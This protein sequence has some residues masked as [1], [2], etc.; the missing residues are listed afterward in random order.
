M[1]VGRNLPCPCGSGK[2]Y[3]TCCDGRQSIP[4][5]ASTDALFMQAQRAHAEGRL[6][7]AQAIYA[8]ILEKDPNNPEAIHFQGLLSHQTGQTQLALNLIERSLALRP[9]N[10]HF[11]TN[12]ALIYQAAGDW[13]KAVISRRKLTQLT[14]DNAKAWHNLGEALVQLGH[15]DEVIEAYRHAANLA[16]SDSALWTDLS[17]RLIHRAHPADLE[18]ALAHSRKVI[19]L[20]PDNAEGHNNLAVALGLL[21]RREEAIKAAQTAIRLTPQSSQP[22][23]NLARIHVLSG[24]VNSALDAYEKGAALAPDVDLFYK[25][26]ANL[27][28]QAGKFNDAI[29]FL[30]LLYERDPKNLAML[31]SFIRYQKFVSV[32]DPL[33]LTARSAVDAAEDKEEGVSMLC[34]VLGS[35]LDKMEQYAAAFGYYNRGNRI[36]A[37]TLHY[38]REAHQRYV[39]SII[40][41]YDTDAIAKLSALGNPSDKPI[42]IVGMPRS[43]TT[44][45]EQIIAV[46]PQVAGGGERDFWGANEPKNDALNQT[47]VNNIA[48]ACLKDL[49]SIPGAD[50][51]RKTTDKMPGNFLR[52]GLIH[53]AFPNARIIHVRRHPVDNCLSIFFQSFNELHQYAFNLEDLVHYR[54][55]YERLMRHWRKVMPAD[56]YFEF[57]Y[58]DLV[59][60][61][62]GMSRKLINFCGLEWDDSSLNYHQNDQ[63]IKTASMWQ[64]RQKI[65]TTSVERWKNYAR[66]IQPLMTLLENPAGAPD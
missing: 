57:D 17:V 1:K 23:L 60:D 49:A 45:T 3:K 9:Q 15:T 34:F 19:S 63:V 40:Q 5:K 41:M 43:G 11:L 10:I 22:W 26:L 24:D 42:I 50:Q 8:T 31:G 51:A 59:A 39:D 12:A 28:T 36:R 46:H 14:P 55:E 29:P 27:L 56:R 13:T 32:D 52:V 7:Q 58:E 4:D 18:E 37:Q 61:Q 30:R 2:K 47:L 20:T 65:Y 35:I 53:A 66:Y 48:Q 38:D 33:L 25:S 62:E 64:V 16:K 21:Q 6:A 54:Q 44:L